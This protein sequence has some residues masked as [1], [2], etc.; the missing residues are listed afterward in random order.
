MGI[1]K[2]RPLGTSEPADEASATYRSQ[3]PSKIIV[4]PSI[5]D[6]D[7]KRHLLALREF[8]EILKGPW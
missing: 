5:Q 1:G 2:F 8:I 7:E 6:Q 4:T 3:P